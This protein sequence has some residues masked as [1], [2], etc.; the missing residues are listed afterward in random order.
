[1]WL[2]VPRKKWEE[3]SEGRKVG[4]YI[5]FCIVLPYFLTE[6]HECFYGKHLFLTDVF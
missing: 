2:N 6:E 1:M 3:V 4:Y 5:I